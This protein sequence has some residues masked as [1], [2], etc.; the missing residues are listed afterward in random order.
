MLIDHPCSTGCKWSHSIYSRGDVPSVY[1]SNVP[2]PGSP[3]G[4]QCVFLSLAASLADP[5]AAVQIWIL[6]AGEGP[7]VAD[8]NM[9]L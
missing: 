5:L 4:R 7:L 2:K 6:L 8:N 9:N 1:R 3:L